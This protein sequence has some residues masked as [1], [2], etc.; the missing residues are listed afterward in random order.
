M[1]T[2]LTLA[3]LLLIAP[4]PLQAV[5]LWQYPETAEKNSLFLG[6]L[7]ASF[8]FGMRNAPSASLTMLEPSDQSRA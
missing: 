6:V 7:A 8:S 4:C 3:V 5:N 2:I 1:K